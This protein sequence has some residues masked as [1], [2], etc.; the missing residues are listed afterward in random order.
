MRTA[1]IVALA[2]GAL[3][4]GGAL[5]MMP[6]AVYEEGRANAPYHLEVEI[7]AVAAPEEAIGV[8]GV[9]ARVVT[10]LR[11]MPGSIARD[12]EVGFD[13]DCLRADADPSQIPDCVLFEP[14]EELLPGRLLDVYLEDE[15][16]GFA[17][18]LGQVNLIEQAG[19]SGS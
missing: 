16:F 19:A 1:L 8:C 2:T 12:Q 17:V 15:L 5:A 13:I 7:L 3:W 14:V 9:T 4:T 18:V 11:D 6:S 10:V